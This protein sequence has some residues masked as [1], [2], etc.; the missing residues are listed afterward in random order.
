M[1][2][3]ET[4]KRLIDNYFDGQTSC[5]EE[6]LLVEYFSQEEVKESFREYQDYFVALGILQEKN[7]KEEIFQEKRR[8]KPFL[9]ARRSIFTAIAAASIAA[10][11]LLTTFFYQNHHS[12][13]VVIDGVKYYDRKN[14]ET[15]FEK[16]IQNVK[17]DMTD[18]RTILND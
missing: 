12:G 1:I 6:Q 5:R 8:K 15:A 16:S 9:S 14:M 10:L 7:R 3:T 18:F 4:I 2:H 17:I 13:Y 11:V